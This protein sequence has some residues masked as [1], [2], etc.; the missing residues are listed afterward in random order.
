[1]AAWTP[2]LSL[3]FSATPAYIG[4]DHADW[5]KDIGDRDKWYDSGSLSFTLAF[6]LANLLPWSANRQQAKDLQANIDKLNLTLD[7]V[8]ENYKLEVRQAVDKL[9][10]AKDKI[11]S[12]TR[13]IALAQE[14]YDVTYRN[15]RNGMTE[16]LD[17]RDSETSLNQA[18]L[19][20]LNQKFEYISALL[21]LETKL[22]TTL[23][24]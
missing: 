6:N 11:D 10:Q 1:M 12:M 22:N 13:N 9:V 20:L 18:K 24:K 3:N 21:D 2:D 15:Y 19:G 16:L 5:I 8:K 4:T 17:L 7:T 14:A 23:S